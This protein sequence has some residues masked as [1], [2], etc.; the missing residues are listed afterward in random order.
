MPTNRAGESELHALLIGVDRYSQN[1]RPALG[2]YPDLHG[3]ANDAERLCR[4]LLERGMPRERIRKLTAPQDGRE[5]ASESPT[6]ENIVAEMERLH[7]KARPG[8]RILIT[9]SGHGGRVPTRCPE[10]KGPDGIDEVL[11]PGR[12]ADLRTRYLHD[13]ELAVL[14]RRMRDQGLLVTLVLDCCHAGGLSR[15]SQVRG[16]GEIDR[17]ERPRESLV[18]SRAEL[19][20]TWRKLRGRRQ[21]SLTVA[22]GWLPDPQGYVL[23]AACQAYQLAEESPRDALG[24]GGAFTW[25][26]LDA[27]R[28][29]GNHAT[30]RELHHSVHSELL[31]ELEGTQTPQVEG[32]ID[33]VFLGLDKRPAP[34][35]GRRR[36]ASDPQPGMSPELTDQLQVTFHR[37][38]VDFD[39]DRTGRLSLLAKC[40]QPLPLMSHVK[41]G[42]WLCLILENTSLQPLHVAVFDHD[43]DGGVSRVFPATGIGEAGLLAPRAREPLPLR[44]QLSQERR[45]GTD[46]LRTV[47]ATD[48]A[49]FLPRAGEDDIACD[50]TQVR[51]EIH[52]VRE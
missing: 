52:M 37:L 38:P 16:T 14:L 8:D 13:V 10:E 30:C 39:P 50:W 48:A 12:I 18:A 29:L 7:T 25:W 17:S 36:L 46:M 45:C 47:A 31:R 11:V 41:V 42:E 40:R 1:G 21:R 33:R 9:F 49:F 51:R 28:R 43:S 26:L 6:Y 3:A 4:F 27:A 23:L 32:D 20:R 15:K 19:A 44:A 5:E 2:L 34:E 35:L 24:K 22:S